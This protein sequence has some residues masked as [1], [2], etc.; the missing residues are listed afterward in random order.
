MNEVG[1]GGKG[2]S[3]WL[4]WFFYKVLSDFIPL[5]LHMKDT[6]YALHSLKQEGT[7]C[8]GALMKIAGTAAGICGLSMMTAQ[9]WAPRTMT[10]A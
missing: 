8:S 4:G 10:S 3:V 9:S 2:E 5:C 7:G 6:E 1:I